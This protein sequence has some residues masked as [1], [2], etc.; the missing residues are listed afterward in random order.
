METP[1]TAPCV[2]EAIPDAPPVPTQFVPAPRIGIQH[3]MLW[4]FWTAAF[5]AFSRGMVRYLAS[6]ELGESS[7]DIV[8]LVT[9]VLWA[10]I[11]GA[12]FT[13][14]CALIIEWFR[15][16]LPVLQH[17][18]YVLILMSALAFASSLVYQ[19]AYLLLK[20]CGLQ[21]YLPMM[22]LSALSV[23]AVAL[24]CAMATRQM[25]EPAWKWAMI[26]AS[27]TY[28]LQLLNI[29]W[30][31]SSHWGMFDSVLGAQYRLQTITSYMPMLLGIY[32]LAAAIYDFRTGMRR[33]WLHWTGVV[34]LVGMTAV[35]AV[36]M[37]AIRLL[38]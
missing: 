10:M 30:N 11:F 13:G 2:P 8:F 14:A 6:M 19:L 32:V 34:S 3:L 22:I 18:G 16:H 5:L 17:P 31:L 37:L 27:T 38:H 1:T 15:K 7:T 29:L 28:V 36:Q 21:G 24:L 33:D 35:S 9:G 20:W 4:M 26:L 25:E 23:S 12:V